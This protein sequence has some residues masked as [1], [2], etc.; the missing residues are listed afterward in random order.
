MRVPNPRLVGD[1]KNTE[2]VPK[3]LGNLTRG[4]QILYDTGF[5]LYM[6]MT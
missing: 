5:K 3:S 1:T 2:G 6:D 4:C